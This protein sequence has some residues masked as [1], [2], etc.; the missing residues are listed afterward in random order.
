MKRNRVQSAFIL[1]L[2]L[3]SF[4]HCTTHTPS[5]AS[6]Y[7][8]Y[9]DDDLS[10]EVF[11]KPDGHIYSYHPSDASPENDFW[12]QKGKRITMTMN[13][14]YAVYKGQLINDS[15]MIGKGRSKGFKWKWGAKFV[16]KN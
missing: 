2:A 16:V 15:T 12:K 3:C 10:Y 13:D 9:T 1:L 7:W 8:R 11:F 4:T 14:S 6:T 5:V